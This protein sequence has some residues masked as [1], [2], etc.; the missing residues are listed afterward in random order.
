MAAV[1][2][3]ADREADEDGQHDARLFQREPQDQENDENRH[4]A[5]EGGAVGDGGEFLIRKGHGSGEAHPDAVVRRQPQFRNRGPDSLGRL[6]SG[7][8][9]AVIEDGLDVD[10]PPEV[11]RFRRFARD[12]PAPGEGRMLPFNGSARRRSR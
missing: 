6:A 10:E 11:R 7:L 3:K 5:I 2:I 4:D 1:K 12:E 8:E 9:R